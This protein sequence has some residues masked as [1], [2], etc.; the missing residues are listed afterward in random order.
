MRTL[1]LGWQ[2]IIYNLEHFRRKVNLVR[3]KSL[4]EAVID[5]PLSK[6]IAGRR[7]C[8]QHVP[9]TKVGVLRHSLMQCCPITFDR[10]ISHY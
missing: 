5:K 2:E 10:T 9:L 4:H 6:V 7:G 3:Y 8:N 1:T